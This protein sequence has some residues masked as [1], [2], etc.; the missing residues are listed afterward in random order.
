MSSAKPY[1]LYT[2][3]LCPYAQRAEL[4]LHESKQVDNVERVEIDILNPREP[5]Y[6][7]KINPVGKVPALAIK[8][9]EHAVVPESLV[10]ANFFAEAF[11]KS[12]LLPESV[13][14]RAR[15]RYVIERASQLISS[16]YPS[17]LVKGDHDSV[18]DLYNSLVELEKL[19]NSISPTG[20]FVFGEELNLA[21]I[22]IAPFIARILITTDPEL[23]IITKETFSPSL[24]ERF[25]KELPR[26][27]A[28]H[29][30]IQARPSWSNTFD[31]EHVAKVSKERFIAFRAKA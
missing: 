20:P 29:D 18:E 1:T 31:A 6:L 27:K 23:G 30:A 26:L 2:S 13:V 9:E 19:F 10:I 28:F 14:Q 25:E 24:P 4:A 11:P 15:V 12:G 8:T 7:E 5:W 22:S 16:N 17:A 21:D 3:K